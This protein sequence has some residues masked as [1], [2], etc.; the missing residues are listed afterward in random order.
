MYKPKMPTKYKN[1]SENSDKLDI[2]HFDELADCAI[3][4]NNYSADPA[5]KNYDIPR[6]C[7]KQYPTN[8]Q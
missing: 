3:L 1:F 6:N 4:L 8:K 7:T 2:N 5:N